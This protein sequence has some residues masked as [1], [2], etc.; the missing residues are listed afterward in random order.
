MQKKRAN[1][2]DESYSNFMLKSEP[3][4]TFLPLNGSQLNS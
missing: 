2:K 3:V 4:D 1:S